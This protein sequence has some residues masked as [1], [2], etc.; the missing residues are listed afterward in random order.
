MPKSVG[1]DR[2]DE[3]TLGQRNVLDAL[4]TEFEIRHS[5]RFTVCLTVK[6]GIWE[7]VEINPQK[8]VIRTSGRVRPPR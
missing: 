3:L 1:G 7:M 2:D 5:R 4:V 6:D 8:R